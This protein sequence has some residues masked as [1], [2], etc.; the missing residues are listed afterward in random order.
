MSLV[1]S[2][3]SKRFEGASGDTLRDISL[4]IEDGEFACVIGPSGCGKTTLLN[5]IAGLEVPTAGSVF[6][7]GAPIAGPGPDRV[8]MFQESALFPWMTV[9]DNVKFGLRLA[10]KTKAQQE[11]I[12]LHYLQMV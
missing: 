9:L 3:I 2:N 1:L 8:V 6:L 10:G 7:D 12:A 11:E 5:I 4:A